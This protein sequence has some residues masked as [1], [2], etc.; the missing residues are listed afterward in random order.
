[1]SGQKYVVIGAGPVGALAALYAAHRGHQVEVYE[2]RGG[3]YMF[4]SSPALSLCVF[5]CPLRSLQQGHVL[6]NFKY[7][8]PNRPS[9]SKYGASQLHKVHQPRPLRTWYPRSERCWTSRSSE[10]STGGDPSNVRSYDPRIQI[11]RT[12]RGVTAV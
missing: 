5:R 8:Y 10:C 1:M 11:W 9:G 12:I 2:L 4:L 7:L 3:M 6:S